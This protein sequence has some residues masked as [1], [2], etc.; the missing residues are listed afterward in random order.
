MLSVIVLHLGVKHFSR[1]Y[2]IIN[3]IYKKINP[4]LISYTFK[5]LFLEMAL[6]AVLYLYCF[7]IQNTFGILSLTLLIIDI[8]GIALGLLCWKVVT[9]LDGQ[10]TALLYNNEIG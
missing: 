7:T 2:K 8:C 5:L 6:N 4:Y 9:E 1:R 10:Q 3:S